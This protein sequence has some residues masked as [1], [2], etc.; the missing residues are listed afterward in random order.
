MKKLI[1]LFV[2]VG[3][4]MAYISDL[5]DHTQNVVKTAKSALRQSGP[6]ITGTVL[7]GDLAWAPKHPIVTLLWLVDGSTGEKYV[8]GDFV[9]LDPRNGNLTFKLQLPAEPHW[10]ALSI[11]DGCYLGL[12]YVI[13]FDDIDG[14]GILSRDVDKLVARSFYAIQYARE[15]GRT[16]KKRQV[17]LTQEGTPVPLGY[18]QVPSEGKYRRRSVGSP[19]RR[20]LQH[21]NHETRRSI[22]I[23]LS[24]H[25]VGRREMRDWRAGRVRRQEDK[26]SDVST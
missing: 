26:E 14:N 21:P 5:F 15:L 10:N 25:P 23:R 7:T 9:P 24:S 20:R 16:A 1:A 2:I 19:H 13:L 6:V 22:N 8:Q 3:L 17:V 11:V 18:S 4:V 12:A